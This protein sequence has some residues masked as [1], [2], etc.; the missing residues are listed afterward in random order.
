MVEQPRSAPALFL[1]YKTG[2]HL[3]VLR[4]FLWGLSRISNSVFTRHQVTVLY[5]RAKVVYSH[6]TVIRWRHLNLVPAR[7]RAKK[8]DHPK[9]MCCKGLLTVDAV[10]DLRIPRITSNNSPLIVQEWVYV[11]GD[12]GL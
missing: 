1:G 3:I 8:E 7:L 2:S 11:V 4:I 5:S 10:V 6:R 9:L 12:V